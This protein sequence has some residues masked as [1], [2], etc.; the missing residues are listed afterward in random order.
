MKHVAEDARG[1]VVGGAAFDGD[2]FGDGDL[3]VVDVIAVP[4]RLEDGV[5]EAQNQKVLHCLFAEVMVDAIDLVLGELA[6]DRLVQSL[7]A[8]LVGAEGFFHNQMPRAAVVAGQ[9]AR[10][11]V[12]DSRCVELGRGGQVV[13]ARARTARFVFVEQRLE[14]AKVFRFLQV[15]RQIEDRLGERVPTCAVEPVAGMLGGRRGQL[16][17][18]HLVREFRARESDD[19][20]ISR[21]PA[22]AMKLVERRH[23]LP[24]G[25]IARGTEDDESVHERGE[26]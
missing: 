12:G 16:L 14:P 3:H 1:V 11:Q 4:D 7:G 13:N 9:A 23:Q 5:G 26:D 25:Q 20:R 15:A 21:Q 22:L 24:P 2:L 10:A 18:P 19:S 8:G 17:S 6:V